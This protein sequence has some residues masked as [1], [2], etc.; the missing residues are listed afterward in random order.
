MEVDKDRYFSGQL[1]TSHNGFKI[2]GV[3]LHSQSKTDMRKR[4]IFFILGFILIILVTGIA[5]IVTVLNRPFQVEKGTYLYIDT[6]DNI[7]SVYHKLTTQ[8]LS[9]QSIGQLPDCLQ[10]FEI[11]S[12]N[13]RQPDIAERTHCR[14]T[15]ENCI[16]SADDRLLQPGPAID[17]QHILCPDRLQHRNTPLPVYSEYLRSL[18]DHDTRSIR[19]TDAKGTRPFLE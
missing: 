8:S 5:G 12:P 14:K 15:V 9:V 7:D 13:S 19:Q 3:Y 11:R 18:L 2:F 4:Y 6:D 16:S 10:A 1:C 17:G